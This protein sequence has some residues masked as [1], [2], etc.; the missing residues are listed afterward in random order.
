MDVEGNGHGSPLQ[1]WM[2][3]LMRLN[4][5]PWCLIEPCPAGGGVMAFGDEPKEQAEC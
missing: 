2:V 4:V 1:G 3:S 5:A